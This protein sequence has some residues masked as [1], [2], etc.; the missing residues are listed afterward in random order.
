MECPALL[1]QSA[2]TRRAN[3]VDSTGGECAESNALPVQP[4][5][6]VLTSRGNAIDS[7]A[8][9]HRQPTRLLPHLPAPPYSPPPTR[10]PVLTYG[11]YAVL[12]Y[13]RPP[14]RCY[15][16]SSTDLRRPPTLSYAVSDTDL[17]NTVDWTHG[18]QRPP[19]WFDPIT[20]FFGYTPGSGQRFEAV[21]N[22]R[23]TEH[24]LAAQVRRAAAVYGCSGAVYGGC[25]AV[26]GGS[27][28]IYANDAAVYGGSAAILGGV[29]I[30]GG[31]AG[32]YRGCL[33]RRCCYLCWQPRHLRGNAA[34]Y[35]KHRAVVYGNTADDY[36]IT[37]AIYGVHAAIYGSNADM[38]GGSERT[39][40][41]WATAG[42]SSRRTCPTRP[43][44]SCSTL[45]NSSR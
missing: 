29:T 24:S 25:A 16:V 3:A 22:L 17:R 20:K 35:G 37:A 40:T 2:L 6:M 30:L 13:A 10:S 45:A 11:S 4:V 38:K 39:S 18:A 9:D 34:T 27:A 41:T 31:V 15:V 1:V 5:L 36:A 12:T 21:E 32:V 28:A 14:I 44:C 7:T 42:T 33:C 23:G 8:G 43:R 26:Y 19:R